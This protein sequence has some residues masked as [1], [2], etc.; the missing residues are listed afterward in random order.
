M[1]VGWPTERRGEQRHQQLGQGFDG[2]AFLVTGEVDEGGRAEVDDGTL[3]RR[4]A[5]GPKSFPRSLGAW[6]IQPRSR[7]SGLVTF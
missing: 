4:R 2:L 3:W 1:L 5:T 7:A 6:G